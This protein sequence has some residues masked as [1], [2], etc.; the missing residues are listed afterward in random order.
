MT[1]RAVWRWRREGWVAIPLLVLFL[2]SLVSSL[3]RPR[4]DWRFPDWWRRTQ[5]HTP[6]VWRFAQGERVTGLFMVTERDA[7]TPQASPAAP[8]L[9]FLGVYH[10]RMRFLDLLALPAETVVELPG[11]KEG[12]GATHARLKDLYSEEYQR[13][14]GDL[15][16]A[17]ERL[18]RTVEGFL[19]SEDRRVQVDYILQVREEGLTTLVDLLGGLHLKTTTGRV[20]HLM[21]A[22]SLAFLR[23]GRG[24]GDGMAVRGTPEG[25]DPEWRRQVFVKQCLQRA[26]HP[27][28][29]L[30]LI[31]RWRTVRQGG[32]AN[33]SLWDLVHFALEVR[34]L[35]LSDVRVFHLAGRMTRGGWRADPRLIPQTMAVLFGAGPAPAPSPTAGQVPVHREAPTVEV[36]NASPH[37][38]LAYDVTLRL[39][40]Y[41]F[42]VVTFGNYTTRQHRTLVI[43]RTGNVW[44]AHTVAR[45]LAAT[46]ADVVTSVD[47]ARLVDV[48]VILGENYQ[49]LE[50]S[51]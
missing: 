25:H 11:S 32:T 37:S 38:R 16:A 12:Q 36:W 31:P 13:S 19:A 2:G 41:G 45:L 47:P 17:A 46:D 30:R 1:N 10:P 4:P 20:Q 44:T 51:Q 14:Q 26:Q 39:R 40:S 15:R 6:A 27:G 50:G 5:W 43:D 23:G 9:L 22:Q 18:C 42:D 7:A 8:V 35:R 21:G 33:A 3:P 29:L 28:W 49:T 34:G 48:S 24:D